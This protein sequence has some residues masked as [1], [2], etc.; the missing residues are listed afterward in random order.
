M[1]ILEARKDVKSIPNRVRPCGKMR[2]EDNIKM[3]TQKEWG[4][5]VL[6]GDKWRA[7]T[8]TVTKCGAQ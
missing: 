4:I 1:S 7:I 6:N 2:R 8:K 3:G 5:S